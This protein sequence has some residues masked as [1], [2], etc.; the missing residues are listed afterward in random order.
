MA[1]AR[2][3]K[4]KIKSI[5]NTKKITRTMELVATSKA[6]RAQNRVKATAP[7]S[8]K[9]RELLAN[10]TSAGTEF[11]AA[12]PLVRIPWSLM[13]SSSRRVSR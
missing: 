9:L 4:A 3:L 13:M 7:Y 6:Q 2:D 8:V 1:S 11:T 10:L 5:S 12:P